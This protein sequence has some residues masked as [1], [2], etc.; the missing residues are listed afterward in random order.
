MTTSKSLT[1]RIPEDAEVSMRHL[2]GHV[3]FA[4]TPPSSSPQQADY[5]AS[6]AQQLGQIISL[7]GNRLELQGLSA[8]EAV[9]KTLL[10][11]EQTQSFEKLT[12]ENHRLRD[13]LQEQKDRL[14]E[15]VEEAVKRRSE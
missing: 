8:V 10:R 9:R 11:C 3:E 1:I 2:D 6:C 14:H 15:L 5:L 4:I 13:Q 12:E 7:I